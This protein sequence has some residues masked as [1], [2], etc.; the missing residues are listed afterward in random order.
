MNELVPPSYPVTGCMTDSA[1]PSSGLM[2]VTGPT[3]GASA[4]WNTARYRTGL[5]ISAKTMS[6]D[7]RPTGSA[8][9]TATATAGR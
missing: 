9:L 4:D 6:A 1:W 7:P 5:V 8:P 2:L 3:W